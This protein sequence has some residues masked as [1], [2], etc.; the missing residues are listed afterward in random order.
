MSTGALLI[1]LTCNTACGLPIETAPNDGFHLECLFAIEAH[2]RHTPHAH[3]QTIYPLVAGTADGVAAEQAAEQA[4]TLEQ[5]YHTARF[6]GML[7]FTAS[8]KQ[9]HD[10]PG[11]ALLDGM[12]PG[13][14]WHSTAVLVL[15]QRSSKEPLTDCDFL[16]RTCN[17]ISWERVPDV[18]Q[19]C[20]RALRY[21]SDGTTCSTKA[22]PLCAGCNGFLQRVRRCASCE[23]VYYCDKRCQVANWRT[24]KLRCTRLAQ[25]A[26]DV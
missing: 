13:V 17:V 26:L 20:Q 1:S 10:A 21:N 11:F 8:G 16:A 7:Y 15:Y 2:A 18:K 22:I 9:P 4:V 6:R 12:Q 24:H 25:A 23:R 3:W 19:T 14:Y 5:V